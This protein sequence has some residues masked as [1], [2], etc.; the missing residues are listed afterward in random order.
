MSHFQHKISRKLQQVHRYLD[1]VTHRE[2]DTLSLVF[3]TAST[4]VEL[5]AT[6]RVNKHDI[7]TQMFAITLGS[8]SVFVLL[9]VRTFRRDKAARVSGTVAV[10][11]L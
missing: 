9:A 5:V 6:M 2:D 11:L 10:L 8:Q 7:L 4:D 1:K 3:V